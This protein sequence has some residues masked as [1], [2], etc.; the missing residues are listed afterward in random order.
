M[1]KKYE[2]RVIHTYADAYAL[3]AK[4]IT[5]SAKT[6]PR[7]KEGVDVPF[8]EQLSDPKWEISLPALE[9]TLRYVME[10]LHHQ[11]YMLCI[12]DNDVLLCKLDVQTTAPVFREI[13][14]QPIDNNQIS[15]I[16]AKNIRET[17]DK[18]IDRLRVMQCIVKPFSS[19]SKAENTTNEY[20]ELLRGLNLPNGVFILNLTDA[21]ILRNDGKTPFT[22]VTGKTDLGEYNF[23][24][25][26]PILSISG[27]RKYLDIPI[28]N[29]DDVMFV[30]KHPHKYAA[31][32]STYV[33][34]KVTKSNPDPS[35]T[36]NWDDK[37]I[38]KAVFRGGPT[39]CGY[40]DETNMRIKLAKM[41]SRHL[42]AKLTVK[43]GNESV[44]TK[45]IKFDP[46]YG[47]GS[48]NTHIGASGNFLTMADQSQ[49]K[50]IVHV[51]GNVNAYRL[52]ATM[53]T[54]SLILRVTSQYTSWV[55]HMLEHMVHYVPVKAD[56]SDLLDVIR[57][58]E[59]N[60]DK[61]K[62][63]AQNGMNFA[64][65]ILNKTYIQSY[66]KNALW[67]LSEGRPV[68]ILGEIANKTA[69]K[70][71]SPVVVVAAKN[72]TR[73][74]DK[75]TKD[76]VK[77]AKEEEKRLKE[78]AKEEEKRLKEAAKEEEKRLKEAAKE[79][80]KRLKEAAKEEEKRL[81]EAAK[82]EEKRAKEAAKEEKKAKVVVKDD[83]NKVEIET[84]N[85]KQCGRHE[86]YN[87]SRKRCEIKPY[88]RWPK[89]TT[90]DGVYRE[91]AS[92]L[93]DIIGEERFKREYEDV[94]DAATG[95]KIKIRLVD[96]K[97]NKGKIILEK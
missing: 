97:K 25:H 66:M 48:M 6:A 44:D 80:E 68:T 3:G 13:L 52:L 67:S 4:Y 90:E 10:L 81:K 55:D 82:E 39:G 86:Y 75:A 59:R 85:K 49:Y 71:K 1:P 51:D 83:V 14:E 54:G 46:K 95:E 42:D 77:K 26:I 91:I 61:C 96:K 29:Y 73:K 69:K 43:D 8:P 38:A 30:L 70:R 56:L 22:M 19:S 7:L 76:A 31:V 17:V 16:Q 41:K 9:N 23:D 12:G 28:P 21:V 72:K 57:W 87:A 37:K 33:G 94:I 88:T 35:Y 34:A 60:D 11:C 24:K 40:T 47:L 84:V 89:V 79:E 27:Q 58:C 50:Y 2:M 45:A 93:K 36:T 65:S 15:Q 64:R 63:I 74:V 62:E 53:L 78:A 5:T 18:N 92:D 20:L 32:K